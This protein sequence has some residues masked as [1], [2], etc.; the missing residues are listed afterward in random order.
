[1]H[2]PAGHQHLHRAA[3]DH[4]SKKNR[5]GDAE[6]RQRIVAH[7][8]DE[9]GPKVLH[10]S[11]VSLE[12]RLRALSTIDNHSAHASHPDTPNWVDA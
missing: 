3:S 4:V 12:F 9:F 5:R 1:M 7:P 10:P 6:T 11:P 2:A 8:I